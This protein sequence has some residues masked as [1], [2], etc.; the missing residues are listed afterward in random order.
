MKDVVRGAM[1][2]MKNMLILSSIR[3]IL[4]KLF[5]IKIVCLFFTVTNEQL[6]PAMSASLATTSASSALSSGFKMPVKETSLM[7]P[8]PQHV[9]R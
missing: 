3:I 4:T 2:K 7:T 5:R 9:S 8:E 1:I 6:P